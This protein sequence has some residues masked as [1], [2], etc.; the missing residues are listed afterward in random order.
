MIKSMVL[1]CLCLIMAG[2]ASNDSNSISNFFDRL[3]F[4][5]GQE[6]CIRVTGQVALGTNPFINSDV[7]V[8]LV[9]KQGENPDD[10]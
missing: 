2:C 5:E 3:E 8:N 1:V 6:G 4:K 10:C 7:N 9:K